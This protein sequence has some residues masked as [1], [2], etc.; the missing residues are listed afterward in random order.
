MWWHWRLFSSQNNED[1]IISRTLLKTLIVIQ[2]QAM[3]LYPLVASHLPEDIHGYQNLEG[4][5][6]E[7]SG[8]RNGFHS[9]FELH[10]W[11]EIIMK[12]W[13]L[14]KMDQSNSLTFT[15]AYSLTC[16]KPFTTKKLC[17]KTRD[18]LEHAG[19]AGD[20]GYLLKTY[21]QPCNSIIMSAFYAT[22]NSDAG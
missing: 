22:M 11:N 10:W 13:Q 14:K 17:I 21:N 1:H 2:G 8:E 3:K 9:K 19:D 20:A 15:H 4:E 18:V 6:N 16:F 7:S 12:T 5:R